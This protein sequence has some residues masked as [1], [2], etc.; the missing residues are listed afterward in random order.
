[1]ATRY[2]FAEGG[3]R[4]ATTRERKP[5][6]AASPDAR[7]AASVRVERVHCRATSS[8]FTSDGNDRDAHQTTRDEQLVMI[9]GREHAPRADGNLA[10]EHVVELDGF[11]HVRR[12]VGCLRRRRRSRT[13][14]CK[15][16]A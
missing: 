6:S 12:Q 10:H 3:V 4:A 5:G 16:G 11:E 13:S 7:R 8:F 1:M 14:H 15:C 2:A 9:D